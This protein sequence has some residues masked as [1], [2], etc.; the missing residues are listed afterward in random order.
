M[1]NRAGDTPPVRQVRGPV[2]K[3]S[4]VSRKNRGGAF[5]VPVIGPPPGA[6]DR[7]VHRC[8]KRLCPFGRTDR[9]LFLRAQGWRGGCAQ[10][11]KMAGHAR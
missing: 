11:R 3:A 2:P 7:L 9:A 8:Q 6:F 5:W 4:P 10:T 1:M